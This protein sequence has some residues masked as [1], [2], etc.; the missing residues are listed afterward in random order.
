M[1]GIFLHFY[2]GWRT[3]ELTSCLALWGKLS[4]VNMDSINSIWLIDW[5]FCWCAALWWPLMGAQL[6]V[7]PKPKSTAHAGAAGRRPGVADQ[8]EGPP[9]E[10]LHPQQR[11]ALRAGAICGWRWA[12]V[13]RFQLP[14]R[15]H[16]GGVR[17]PRACTHSWLCRAP[18]TYTMHILDGTR[19][20]DGMEKIFVDAQKTS[21]GPAEFVQGNTAQQ[22]C[23][24]VIARPCIPSWWTCC[25]RGGSSNRCSRSTLFI[26]RIH[27]HSSVLH[28]FCVTVLC[29]IIKYI[30]TN[31]LLCLL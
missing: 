21:N 15:Q 17:G 13:R 1:F 19:L 9:E 27:T 22:P 25:C 6:V 10:E 11:A 30:F 8:T 4:F 5:T 29:L 16:S 12:S 7:E 14:L 26:L 31:A 24:C 18:A 28:S 23:V 20:Y 3:E 2:G